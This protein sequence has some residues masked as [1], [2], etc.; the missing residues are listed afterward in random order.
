MSIANDSESAHVQRRVSVQVPSSLGRRFASQPR[1][2]QK[3]RDQMSSSNSDSF[4]E[5]KEKQSN[6][7]KFGE[8]NQLAPGIAKK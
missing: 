5:F 8:I 6:E 3:A 1:R 7:F 2:A 4:N